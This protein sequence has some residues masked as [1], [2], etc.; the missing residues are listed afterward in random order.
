MLDNARMRATAARVVDPLARGLLRL[1]LTPNHVTFLTS[2]ILSVIVLYFWSR[3]EFALG[4][5]VGTPFVFGDL[6]DGTMAR[7]S[8]KTSAWGGFLDSVMDRVTDMAILGSLVL[9]FASQENFVAQGFALW[10]M[11]SS[12]LISY[13]RA[14]AEAV[15]LNGKV[16]LMERTERLIVVALCAL[17]AAFGYPQSMVVCV[18]LLATLNTF[19]L[20]QRLN[21][22]AKSA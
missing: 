8:G 1:G 11:A 19:T 4:F 2:G 17:V 20:W 21:A 9:W 22:V 14:K 10:A 15:N 12:V 18:V 13:V 6:L 7:L 16:G 3:G 5:I